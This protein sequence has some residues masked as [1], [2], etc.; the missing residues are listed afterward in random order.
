MKWNLKKL[1]GRS[2]GPVVGLVTALAV[3]APNIAT[4][5]T[6]PSKPLT[7]IV[8]YAPGGGNDVLARIIAPG[9]SEALG[10]PVVVEN[11]PGAGGTI[12]SNFVAR[13]PADGYTMLIINTLPHTAAAGLYAKLPYDPIKD[14]SSVGGIATVPYVVVIN[15]GVPAKSVSDLV[16][17]ARS[18]PGALN[19]AS[20]GVGSATHLTAE[21]F[22]SATSTNINHVPY[23]GGGPGAT[24]LMGGQVDLIV[25]NILGVSSH[26]RAGKMRAL[27]V[28]SSK[29]SAS[30]PQLPTVA[31]SGYPGFEV[32]GRFGL[33]VPVGTPAE[34]VN[35]LNAALTKAVNDPKTIQLLRAQ[36][37]E[38]AAAKPAAF[39]ALIK[40]DSAKWLGVMRQAGIKAE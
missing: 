36:A 19:Y 37:S 7:I 21:F 34:Q 25:E 5:E 1:A 30:F 24:D 33:V 27:A 17:L 8:P 12:G 28:T 35:R 2:V 31:E 23:K 18:K 15:P 11:R 39:D 6:F 20:A 29:R 16:A 26:I 10:Q 9:F 14:F 4:A 38:P 3:I 22:K 40:A 13:A 32:G